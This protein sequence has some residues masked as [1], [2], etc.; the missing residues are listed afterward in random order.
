MKDMKYLAILIKKRHAHFSKI[1]V[2]LERGPAFPEDYPLSHFSKHTSSPLI[3]PNLQ[4]MIDHEAPPKAAPTKK[5]KIDNKAGSSHGPEPAGRR[6]TR[7]M[8]APITSKPDIVKETNEAKPKAPAKPS[9]KKRARVD[10]DEST[11]DAEPET[12]KAAKAVPVTKAQPKTTGKNQASKSASKAATSTATKS[13]RGASSAAS[14]PVPPSAETLNPAQSGEGNAKTLKRGQKKA[15][16]S[17]TAAE[18]VWPSHEEP[19]AK[20]QKM[21]RAPATKSKSMQPSPVVVTPPEPAD[22]FVFGSNPFGALGLGEDE[23]VKYRPAQVGSEAV[24]E[25]FLQVACGGMHTVALAADGKVWTWGVNDEGALGRKT[26]GTSW[27][28]TAE[29]EKGQ[30]SEPGLAELPQEV[31]APVTQVV[32]GDGFTFALAGGSIYGCGIFKDDQGGLTGFNSRTKGLQRTFIEVH[33]AKAASSKVL[34]LLCGARHIVALTAG[35]EVLTWGISSQGQLGRIPAFG[36]EDQP[37]PSDVFEPKAVPGLEDLLGSTPVDIGVGL[38]NTFAISETGDV[39]GWG[40]NNSGQLGIPKAN[41]DDNLVWIPVKIESLKKIADVRGG[42]QHTLALTKE[43]RVVT[44]G[45]AT[46]GMLGRSGLDVGKASENY[47]VPEEVDGLADHKVTCIAAGMNISGC[48]TSDGAL[49][50]WGS[51][52]NYQLAKGEVEEDSLVPEKLR[53]TKVFGFRNVYSLSFGGQHAA[54]LAG[55]PAEAAPAAPVTAPPAAASEMTEASVIANDATVKG[56]AD[57]PEPAPFVNAAS[58]THDN[59][60]IVEGHTAG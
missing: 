42:E 55:Q 31:K 50:L 30:A 45:A 41:A 58:T 27:E 57:I 20:R 34:K 48:C 59:P 10:N 13:K 7:S 22:L 1:P 51:N 21:G 25:R 47:P 38:Y 3:R 28:D 18:T 60:Q 6:T 15:T 11:K 49:W 39:V 36:Q 8:T 24:P 37:S 19:K 23:T 5:M 53:R 14:K 16:P 12:I 56:T 26:E 32:A 44:F 46:Y 17:V 4:K 35:G 54:L 33:H 29:E 2:N 9:T 52:V 40:L 43:G